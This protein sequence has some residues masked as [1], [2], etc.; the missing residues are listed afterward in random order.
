VTIT[1][2]PAHGTSDVDARSRPMVTPIS[3]RAPRF[4]TWS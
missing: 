2:N 3:I 4:T 1:E